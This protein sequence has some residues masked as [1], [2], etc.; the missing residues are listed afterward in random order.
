[1]IS[2]QDVSA[3]LVEHLTVISSV[4]QL[5][6]DQIREAALQLSQ[7]LAN[8]GTVIWCGNGGSAADSQHMAAELVGRFQKDRRALRSISL[9]ANTSVMTCIANDYKYEDIF[10]RQLQAIA[11]ESDTLMILSTSGNSKNIISALRVAG[12][13]GIKTIA[14]LGKDGGQAKALAGQAI[15]IPSS[16]TARIQEAHIL[17]GHILCDLIEKELGLA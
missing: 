6:L 16:S 10:S 11:R 5:Y 13:L 14:L 1:M 4:S 12:K 8:D 17:I 15:V 7:T 9:N 2:T 3:H